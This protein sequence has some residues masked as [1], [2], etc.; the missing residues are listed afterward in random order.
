METPD[1]DTMTEEFF[2]KIREKARAD[3]PAAPVDIDKRF[4]DTRP[5]PNPE[6]AWDKLRRPKYD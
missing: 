2:N 6:G 4:E 3:H 1:N 5:S